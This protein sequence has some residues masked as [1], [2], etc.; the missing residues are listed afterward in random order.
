MSKIEME[1]EVMRAAGLVDDQIDKLFNLKTKVNTGEI[2]ELT[3]DYKRLTFIKY[4]H[5][6]RDF[7]PGQ[8]PSHRFDHL[9]SLPVLNRRPFVTTRSAEED[10]LREGWLGFTIWQ[11]NRGDYSDD[12][13]ADRKNSDNPKV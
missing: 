12:G 1:V 9:D 7:K 11:E 10:K 13:H 5:D 2:D 6:T 3:Q 8:I 4:L